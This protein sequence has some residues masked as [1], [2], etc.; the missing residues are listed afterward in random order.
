MTEEICQPRMGQKNQGSVR[1]RPPPHPPLIDSYF[2]VLRQVYPCGKL[3]LL[4]HM[5]VLRHMIITIC[6]TTMLCH[7]RLTFFLG[8]LLEM[9][10]FP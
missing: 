6:R 2:V 10:T 3:H 8:L 9:L 4:K 7:P 5:R 1:H